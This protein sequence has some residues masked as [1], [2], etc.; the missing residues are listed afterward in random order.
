MWPVVLGILG[1]G[2]FVSKNAN[3]KII[4]GPNPPTPSPPIPNG[5]RRAL[6]KEVNSAALSL[7]IDRVKSPG[8]VGTFVERDG[9][10]SLTEWHFHEPYGPIK[11]WGWHRG[12]TI[13]VR[14]E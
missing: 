2:I 14:K 7:A 4:T 1:V 5:W 3:A 9:F 12:I 6:P 10:G 13:L 8:A 11:P